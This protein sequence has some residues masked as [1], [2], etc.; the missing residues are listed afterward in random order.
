MKHDDLKEASARL[1]ASLAAAEDFLASQKQQH[2]AACEIGM[3]DVQVEMQSLSE[4]L[5]G[6]NLVDASW[7]AAE[8]VAEAQSI[9]AR[10]TELKVLLLHCRTSMRCCHGL[11][12]A[13][14]IQA[15]S[16]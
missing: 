7:P 16:G 14:A 3:K 1:A 8:S 5:H 6:G 11:S 9:V 13:S 4:L 12:D 10:M 2:M 15:L